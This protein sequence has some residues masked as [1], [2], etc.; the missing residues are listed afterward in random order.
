MGFSIPNS[1]HAEEA[2]AV[3]PHPQLR[4]FKVGPYLADKPVADIGGEGAFQSPR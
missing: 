1:T 2:R 4:R 3:I